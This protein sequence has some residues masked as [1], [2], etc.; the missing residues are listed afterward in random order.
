MSY[1]FATLWYERQRFA[2]AALAVMFS[3]VLIAMQCGLLLGL[4]SATSLPIDESRADVWVGHPE[5]ASVDLGGSIPEVWQAYLSLPEV[6]RI[7]PF[8]EGFGF[9]DKP[10]GGMELVILVGARLGDDSL[11]AAASLNPELRARLSEL[12]SVVVDEGEF[13]RLGISKVGET[14]EV[15]GKRVRVVGAVSG[16][17]NLTAPY[18]FCSVDTA[19]Q[20]LRWPTDHCTFILAKCRDK[21]DAAKVV[22][23]LKD[24]PH[25]L[26][27]F[28]T[29]E[30]SLRS[31]I[32]WLTKTQ[33]GL[34]FGSSAILG[35]LVGTI[36]T[37]QTLYA[38]TIASLREFAILRAMGIP[39]RRM[40]FFAMAQAFWVGV[41]GVTLAMPVII[42][43]VLAVANFGVK[44][45]LPLWLL[46][47]SA[48]ITMIMAVVSGLMALRSLRLVEPATLLR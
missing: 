28:S 13:D 21:R 22:E 47:G 38:A 20:V 15:F 30:F 3:C 8:V 17:R 16:M 32:Y 14:A 18:L 6:E 37:S 12:N 10:T 26:A 42:L 19:Q 4:F 46:G 9:W 24:Y 25:K 44:V 48:A 43:L 39:R 11:G 5:V 40:A 27:A 35:L 23:R 31:R 36:V 29:E 33:A 7:E 34:A 41:C 45:L 2:S 1:A